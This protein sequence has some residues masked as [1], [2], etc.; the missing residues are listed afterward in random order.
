MNMQPTLIAILLTAAL[1]PVTA[2]AAHEDVAGCCNARPQ[3]P[4]VVLATALNGD[5][6]KAGAVGGY[7]AGVL[8][9]SNVRPDPKF[10]PIVLAQSAASGTGSS[11]Q[12]PGYLEL[13]GFS[14]QLIS[15]C[16]GQLQTRLD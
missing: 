7:G 3:S 8:G 4:V 2:S 14:G 10:T 6:E 1:A 16:D 13:P 12:Q 11:T 9:V 5:A 15:V